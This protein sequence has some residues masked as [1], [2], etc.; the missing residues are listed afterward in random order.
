M[1]SI[2]RRTRG[3]TLIELMI[4][5]AIVAIIT[6]IALPNFLADHRHARRADANASLIRIVEAQERYRSSHQTY[7]DTLGDL[8]LSS[9]T[10][11]NLYSIALST[12]ALT[13]STTF[14]VTFTAKNGT[15]QSGDTGCTTMK[16][17]VSSGNF[18]YAQPSC[19]SAT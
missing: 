3:V 6:A 11:Q 7:T 12:S 2:C 15:S 4:A 8:G 9:S 18:T 10:S 5:I 19:F 16:V 14:V 17:T 13:A 1:H